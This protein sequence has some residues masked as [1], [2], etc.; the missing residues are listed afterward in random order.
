MADLTER[1]IRHWAH[2]LYEGAG[3]WRA[4]VCNIGCKRNRRYEPR[5]AAEMAILQFVKGDGVDPVYFE[6]SCYLGGNEAV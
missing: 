3:A 4:S 1:R 2:Q 6:T 5:T